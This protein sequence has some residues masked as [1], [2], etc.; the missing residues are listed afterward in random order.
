[1]TRDYN[2]F[3]MWKDYYD[4]SSNLLDEKVKEDFP[5][6]GMGQILEMNLLFKKVLDE[7][8]ENYLESVNIPTR[9]DIAALSSLIV[10]VDSK[11]DDL[12]ELLEE[13]KEKQASQAGGENQ[14]DL[15]SELT[16]VKK[17]IKDLDNKVNEI[18][19]NY[20]NFPA[21]P[22]EITFDFLNENDHSDYEISGYNDKMLNRRRLLRNLRMLR[23]VFNHY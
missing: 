6:Q 18:L 21:N 16:N 20:D 13:F 1:M 11:V 2:M 12:E 4:Q 14:A 8:T 7:T 9:N 15:Q 22:D 23:N 17:D 19:Y 10:N 3:E 5:S